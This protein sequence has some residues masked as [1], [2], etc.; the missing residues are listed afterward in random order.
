MSHSA[1]SWTTIRHVLLSS[2]IP[3]SLLKFMPTE[4]V[5]LSNHTILC[6]PLFLLASI[7]PRIKVLSNE[8]ALRIKWPKFLR[9]S[10]SISSSNEYSVL[11]SFRIYWFDPLAVQGILKSL[12]QYH[13][14]KESI[15]WCSTFFMFQLSCSYM[16]TGVYI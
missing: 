14:L 11:I 9:S 10:F 8:S 5:M 13:H 7:F 3:W 12:L 2:T 1:T 15:L 16:T 4:L 6:H